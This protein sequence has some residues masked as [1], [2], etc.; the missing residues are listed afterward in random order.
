MAWALVFGL[1][2]LRLPLL[3]LRF[4]PKGANIPY[5]LADLE[6]HLGFALKNLPLVLGGGG[7]L[8]TSFLRG[9]VGVVVAN[10]VP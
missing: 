4:G 7:V 3:P 1:F 6:V 9:S 10:D 5:C 2:L 8:R